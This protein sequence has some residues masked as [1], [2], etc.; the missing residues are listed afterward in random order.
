METVKDIHN[1]ML[2]N[3]DDEYDKNTGSFIYDTT[4]PGAI[5]FETKAR[6]IEAVQSKLDV[7]NLKD[8][9][10]T[11]FVYQRT[12]ISRKLATKSTTTVII[13][14]SVGS[15]IQ[16]GDLVGTDTI[17]FV[18]LEDKAIDETGLMYVLV[19][20]EQFGTIGNVPANT[21][22]KF[23][24]SIPGLV[25]VYNPDQAIN[26][27]EAESDMDL[28]QRY[29]EKLQKPGKAG[30]KYH[31]LE[32]AKAVTGVGDAR[33]VPRW[34]GPLTVKVVLIDSNKHPASLELIDDA[35]AYIE[36]EMPFG[37]D[38]TVISAAGVPINISVT[39]TLA[40]G[41]TELVVIETI[42]EN[43]TQYLQ[44]IAFKSTFVSYAK[45]G[46]FIIDSDGVLDY[47]ELLVNGSTVNISIGE[48]EVAIMGGV[49]E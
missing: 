49:N 3:M 23:P 9:E 43:I 31:Y 20:C 7:E 32:W 48:E 33:V 46:S 42:K 26:G 45:I 14:G 18:S 1:R 22:T 16:I 29:Y 4:M 39:L 38:L 37:A 6:E 44:E 2:T 15:S 47:Q 11:R 41:Y 36:S 34:D 13:S 40:D 17:N 25:N 5:E 35:T 10:L 28:R 21:I 19:E 27:Y 8:D 12:G 24:V 30:N